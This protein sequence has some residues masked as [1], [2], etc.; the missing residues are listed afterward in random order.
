[1]RLLARTQC[2]FSGTGKIHSA[3]SLEQYLRAKF[4]SYVSNIDIKMYGC[5]VI[6]KIKIDNW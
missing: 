2:I 1:M 5:E 3:T 4:E 6:S